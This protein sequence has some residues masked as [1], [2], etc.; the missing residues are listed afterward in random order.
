MNAAAVNGRIPIRLQPIAGESFDGW[1][2]AYAQRLRVSTVQLGHEL[3]LPARLLRARSTT[4]LPL[5]AV[6]AWSGSRRGRAVWIPP[7]SRGYRWACRDTIASSQI[8]SG[9]ARLPM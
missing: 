3:G 6:P 1:L 7:R 4:E 9:R 5:G 8:I 2:D